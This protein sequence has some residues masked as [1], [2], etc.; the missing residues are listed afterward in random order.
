MH[1]ESSSLLQ[2]PPSYANANA[3]AV[4][5]INQNNPDR[6]ALCF[7]GLPRSFKTMVL[8]SIQK[9]ILIPNAKHGC[10]IFVHYY[11]KLEEEAGR[12][13][14]GGKID[15]NEIFL[16]EPSVANISKLS[17]VR[18]TN[19]TDSQFFA[20]RKTELDR[21]EKT[22][23]TDGKPAYYPWKEDGWKPITQVN[24]IR[25][26]HSVERSFQLME[27][28]AQQHN[29]RYRRV[30]MLRNDVMYLTPIDIM[31]LDR[32]LLDS[33]NDHFVLPPFANYPVN[34]RM[35][36]GPY[37]AVKVWATKRFEL[38]EERV[39][40]PNAAGKVL[41]SER[42]MN[43][44]IIPSIEDLGY[45]KHLNPDICFVRTRVN[46]VTMFNDCLR[47]GSTRGID[48]EKELKKLVEE[49]LGK[50]CHKP[51]ASNENRNVKYLNCQ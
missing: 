30:A 48:T 15:P 24:L 18:F 9:N 35:I 33:K 45:T 44:S 25:Q 10:D 37:E 39:K 32:T 23:G 38:I 31:K 12:F 5:T 34:D 1:S 47:F 7:F 43:E 2:L 3:T 17:T 13:N 29:I 20:T 51:V 49:I 6:C 42:F 41:H 4:F 16:L 21:Y 40:N 8:P 27:D 14:E 11:Y 28:Y 19:D 46:S 26:W 36:Y 50:Q 22:A